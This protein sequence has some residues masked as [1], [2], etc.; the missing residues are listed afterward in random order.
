MQYSEGVHVGYRSYAALSLTPRYPF[1]FG[2][3]YATFEYENLS[4]A[5]DDQ[6]LAVVLT[7]SFTLRNSSDTP[8]IE[9]AQVYLRRPD[10]PAL[11]LVG[12][13]REALEAGE[14]R[15]IQLT[16]DATSTERPFSIWN[17][18]AHL[19]EIQPGAY[20]LSVGPSS[21]DLPCRQS[22]LVTSSGDVTFDEAE[23]TS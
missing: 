7:V 23:T 1:G 10:S 13:A 16:L 5:H 18:Q 3:S 19:W 9:I 2:L 14:E 22:F 6:R 12:W 4:L 21:V 17:D 8:G 15:L 20:T 11:K